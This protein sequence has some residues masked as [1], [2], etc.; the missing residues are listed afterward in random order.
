[1]IEAELISNGIAFK[2][3][4]SGVRSIGFISSAKPNAIIAL[5][6]TGIALTL[7]IKAIIY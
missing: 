6:I 1:M 4:K 3:A 7:I 2:I 5:C